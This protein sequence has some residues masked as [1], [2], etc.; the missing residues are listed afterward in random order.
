MDDEDRYTRITL[1][2]PK[3]LDRKLQEQADATSKSKNA[4]IVARLEASF[5]D[6]A[7]DLPLALVH[8]VKSAV[9]VASERGAEAAYKRILES[10]GVLNAGAASA[11]ERA[12]AE[13]DKA[14]HIG[15]ATKALDDANWAVKFQEALSASDRILKAT[16]Q[17]NTLE[18]LVKKLEE[19][20]LT[21]RLAMAASQVE[22][23]AEL[24]GPPAHLRATLAYAEELDRAA[25]G[26][27][28]DPQPPVTHDRTTLTK[29]LLAEPK[30]KQP[31]RQRR[32]NLKPKK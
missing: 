11:V 19:S 13:L 27:A 23:L 14:D 3:D 6:P 8:D 30:P 32:L 28:V 2:L 17:I 12:L 29:G 10:S 15:R 24:A 31:S 1:R 22:R 26:E 5:K 16:E 21:S 4:E 25:K 7:Q 9:E 20:N 18:S